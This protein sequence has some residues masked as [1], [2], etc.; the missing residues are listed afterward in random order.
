MNLN[1]LIAANESE[2]LDFKAKYHSDNLNFLHD[3]LCLAN[4]FADSNRYLVFG[5]E[6]DKTI[7]GVEA[8]SNRKNN[9]GIHDLLRQSNFNRIPT[10]ELKTHSVQGNEVDVL[11]IKNRPDKPFYLTKDKSGNQKT[12]RAGVIY[13]RISDTNIPLKESAPD[14]HIELMWRERFGLGLDPLSRLLRLLDDKVNWIS[15]SGDSYL[16]HK[17]FPEFT[18]S[19]GEKVTEDFREKWTLKFPDQ[20]AWSYYIE[21]KYH[22]TILER[23]LFVVC[24]GGRYSVPLPTYKGN[25]TWTIDTSSLDYKISEI[26]QQHLPLPEALRSVGVYLE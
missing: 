15:I 17:D 21:C 7:C 1:S 25:G 14:D 11:E 6:D 18:I 19:D 16:Y 5:I 4:S 22:S 3:L 12:I 13:T 24:D 10:V 2:W 9:A 23:S 26:Y 8:D 20:K